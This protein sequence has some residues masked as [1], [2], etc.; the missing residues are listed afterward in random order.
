MV[1]TDARKCIKIHE[2]IPQRP[3]RSVPYYHNLTSP[4][5]LAKYIISKIESKIRQKHDIGYSVPDVFELKLSDEK[6]VSIF[7]VMQLHRYVKLLYL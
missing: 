1:Q 3:C 5:P 6:D 2:I 4:I 7:R